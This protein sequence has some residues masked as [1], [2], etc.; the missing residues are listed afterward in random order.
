MRQ[1]KFKL[2][3]CLGKYDLDFKNPKS[4]PKGWLTPAKLMKQY[5]T[6]IKK[7]P[8]VSIEDPFDQEDFASW[9]KI[10]NAV[11][12]QVVADMLCSSNIERI[13]SAAEKGAA[14]CLLLK[15]TKTVHCD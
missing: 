9:T 2:C 12:I 3:N 15:V 10:K 5:Q 8:V 6:L 4:K 7:F 11:D 1:L 13:Q 14:N